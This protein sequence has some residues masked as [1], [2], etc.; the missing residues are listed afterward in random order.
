MTFY[1]QAHLQQLNVAITDSNNNYDNSP[2]CC[3][4]LSRGINSGVGINMWLIL[5]TVSL[6]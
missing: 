2:G 1:A 3:C 4:Q 6:S 5:E